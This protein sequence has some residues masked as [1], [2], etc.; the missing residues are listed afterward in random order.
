MALDLTMLAQI[1][2]STGPDWP[3]LS[4]HRHPLLDNCTIVL[5]QYSHPLLFSCMVVLSQHRRPLLFNHMVVQSANRKSKQSL[6]TGL[7]CSL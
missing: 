3:M 4:Q 5:S 1:C 6:L 7:C 2:S